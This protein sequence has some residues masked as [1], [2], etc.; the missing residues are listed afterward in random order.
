MEQIGVLLAGKDKIMAMEFRKPA[1]NIFPSVYYRDPL[2]AVEWLGQAFGFQKYQMY[3]G[4]DGTPVHIE[5]RFGPGILFVGSASPEVLAQDPALNR[6]GIYV[7]VEHLDAHCEQA[8]ESGAEIVMEPMDTDYGA[9][10]YAARDLDGN[11][12][13]FGTYR[14]D[15][16]NDLQ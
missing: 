6:V 5:L 8:R 9:R 14:P 1:Q 11:L 10:Q 3:P 16:P 4:E 7:T 15:P 13:Y 2:K 12:W